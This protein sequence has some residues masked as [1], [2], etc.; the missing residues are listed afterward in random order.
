MFEDGI[1]PNARGY[2]ELAQVWLSAI[3]ADA[4]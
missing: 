3:G 1:H 2:E 4:R